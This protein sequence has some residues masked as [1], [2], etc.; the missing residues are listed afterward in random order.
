MSRT[1][2]QRIVFAGEV[3]P[4][5]EVAEALAVPAG[6]RVV[7]RRRIILLDD[8]LVEVADSYYPLYVAQGTRL[9][10]ASKIPGGAVSLL[11]ELGHATKSTVEDVSARLPTSDEC[12]LLGTTAGEPVLILF[13]VV[14][15]DERRPV[16]VS[17]MTMIAK[18][19]HL[20]Y[21]L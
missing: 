5:S 17:I 19:R 4:P 20:R 13:R 9:A 18:G 6:E 21:Q 1:G 8:V 2:T 14:F 10:E 12:E 3:T 15:A 11:A 7:L 16:E